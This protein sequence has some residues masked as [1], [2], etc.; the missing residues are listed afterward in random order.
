[1][2]LLSKHDSI[3]H[4]NTLFGTY[5]LSLLCKS[6]LTYITHSCL[7]LIIKLNMNYFD[8]FNSVFPGHIKKIIKTWGKSMN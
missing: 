2:Y 7:L 8:A 4:D 1:M 3:S 5:F 6:F